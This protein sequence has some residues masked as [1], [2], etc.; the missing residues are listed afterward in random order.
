MFNEQPEVFAVDGDTIAYRTAAACET[1]FEGA[2][3]SIIMS[4]LQHIVN[5][6]G[7]SRMRIYLGGSKNFRYAAAKTKPYKGNRVSM[8]RPQFL[9]FCR[10]FL[11][12]ECNAMIVS[13]FEADDA[14]ATDMYWNGAIHMGV[15]KDILQCPGKHYNYVKKEWKTITED[16]AILRLYRQVLMGDTSDNIP[17]LPRI[18]KA[19]AA[20]RIVDPLTAID[21]A[22]EMYKEV[23]AAKLPGVNPYE[24]MAEQ[25]SLI[26]M[27]TDVKLDY[28]STFDMEVDTAGFESHDNEVDNNNVKRSLRL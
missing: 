9:G 27:R 20:N 4:T 17:G 16:E 7:I 21:D 25:L 2:C 26:K 18:G 15:D 3:S 5:D 8:V 10:D 28:S 11:V 1:H 24:Y 6:T 12:E 22:M 14:I 13:G 23:C 19:K